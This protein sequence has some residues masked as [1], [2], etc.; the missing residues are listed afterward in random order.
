MS[1]STFAL[2]VDDIVEVF[3]FEQWLRYYFVA[4][5]DGRL[6]L[7]IPPDELKRLYEKYEHL[8]PLADML[9]REEISY[10]KSQ[11]TVCTFVGA[12]Y[13]GSKYAA[14]VISRALD[15]KAFKIELYVFGVWMKGHEAY[16]DAQ[17]LDFADWREMYAGW[18]SMEEVKDYRRKLMAGG[19]DPNQPASNAVN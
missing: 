7:E 16:L 2:A 4:E 15:S 6:F 10:E 12:R 3:M 1:E 18:N 11:A 17:R 5:K 9:N 13:D 14:G 8:A 19:G